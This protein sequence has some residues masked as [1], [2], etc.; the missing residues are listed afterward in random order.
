MG[1]N[2]VSTKEV[3][4]WQAAWPR[5]TEYADGRFYEGE[6]KDGMPWNGQGTYKYSDGG[7]YKGAFVDGKRNGQGKLTGKMEAFTKESEGW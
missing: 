7:V 5:K 3:C 1:T 6:W 4:R 2:G